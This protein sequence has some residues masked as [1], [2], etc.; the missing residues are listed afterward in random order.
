MEKFIDVLDVK[1]IKSIY[2]IWATFHVKE[3]KL[4]SPFCDRETV[5]AMEIEKLKNIWTS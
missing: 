5:V 1:A 2:S 3:E 4:P